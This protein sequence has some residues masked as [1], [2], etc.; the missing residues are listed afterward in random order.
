MSPLFFACCYFWYQHQTMAE[1]TIAKPEDAIEREHEL[2]AKHSQ[3]HNQ[4]CPPTA[5]DSK[6]Y[7][8]F[9]IVSE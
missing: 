5:E 1:S 3:S 9:G 2:E 4:S 6:I 8:I 7:E